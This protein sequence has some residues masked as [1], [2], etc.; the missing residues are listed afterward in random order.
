MEDHELDEGGDEGSVE[1]GDEGGLEWLWLADDQFEEDVDAICAEARAADAA[2]ERPKRKRAALMVPTVRLEGATG[3][4]ALINGEYAEDVEWPQLVLTNGTSFMWT[5]EGRWCVGKRRNVG[6]SKCRAFV[7]SEPVPGRP[8]DIP[9]GATW[10]VNDGIAAEFA[11]SASIRLVLTPAGRAQVRRGRR[12][13]TVQRLGAYSAA[14]DERLAAQLV[15]SAADQQ[16]VGGVLVENGGVWGPRCN[17][18]L[19]S[20]LVAGLRVASLQL[21]S[22]LWREEDA[23]E[24][25]ELLSPACGLETLCVAYGMVGLGGLR[26]IIAAARRCPTLHTVDVFNCGPRTEQ[27]DSLGCFSREGPESEDCQLLLELHQVLRGRRPEMV[28]NEG[29]VRNEAF[30]D[31]VHGGGA[32]LGHLSLRGSSLGEASDGPGSFRWSEGVSSDEGGND[33]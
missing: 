13:A 7:Q 32:L 4:A 26:A 8:E 11:A 20:A 17:A 27:W 21:T 30:M 18:A 23:V 28:S 25:A 5:H 6:S 16:A 33:S 15:A 19:R 9:R 12:P 2:S 31:D 14:A 10:M 24:L 3:H 29:C 1:G 22:T